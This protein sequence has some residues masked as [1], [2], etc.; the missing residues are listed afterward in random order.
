VRRATAPLQ[1]LP[2]PQVLQAPLARLARQAP[3]V[4]S[5]LQAPLVRSA[6]QA[7]LARSARLALKVIPGPSCHSWCKPL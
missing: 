1:D 4:R 6:L 5:A 3:L 7:P 2:A